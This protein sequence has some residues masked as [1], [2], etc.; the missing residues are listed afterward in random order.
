MIELQLSTTEV[1]L[2]YSLETDSFTLPSD[3]VKPIFDSLT[4]NCGMKDIGNCFLINKQWNHIVNECVDSPFFK[5][6]TFVYADKLFMKELKIALKIINS[7]ISLNKNG[8][9]VPGYEIRQFNMLK[10]KNFQVE[11]CNV[12]AVLTL[13]NDSRHC[14]EQTFQDLAIYVSFDKNYKPLSIEDD[15]HKTI[16]KTMKHTEFFKEFNLFEEINR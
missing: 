1:N 3:L 16:Y 9:Y 5:W 13:T 12:K 10:R 14:L 6:N 7:A 15:A 2:N 4:F 8:C 11:L